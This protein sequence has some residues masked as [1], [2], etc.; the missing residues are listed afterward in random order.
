MSIDYPDDNSTMVVTN[1]FMKDFTIPETWNLDATAITGP[2]AKKDMEEKEIK[3]NFESKKDENEV[4]KTTNED[5]VE[6]DDVQSNE[7]DAS[8]ESAKP[9]TPVEELMDTKTETDVKEEN[10][11]EKEESI[12]E[13]EDK[14]NDTFSKEKIVTSVEHENDASVEHLDKNLPISDPEHFDE[15]LPISDPEQEGRAN[16]L[17]SSDLEDSEEAKRVE[18]PDDLLSRS[19]P[20]KQLLKM[21][22]WENPIRLKK[23]EDEWTQFDL[24]FNDEEISREKRRSA[25]INT[26]VSVESEDMFHRYSKSANVTQ[27]AN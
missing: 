16:Q 17:L 6:V 7:E 5:P 25:V 19:Y 24:V 12:D 11:D 2:I 10:I 13:E 1:L 4:K 14:E 18:N 26:Q 23:N 9:V 20:A 15:S 22:W 8:E 21:K 3:D 27:T